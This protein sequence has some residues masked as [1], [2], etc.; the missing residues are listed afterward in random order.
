MHRDALEDMSY[1]VPPP[2]DDELL[3]FA[4]DVVDAARILTWDR[5]PTEGEL[6]K[7]LRDR[8]WPC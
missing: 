7:N 4:D 1:P 3:R 8:G 2:P 5:P 6:R